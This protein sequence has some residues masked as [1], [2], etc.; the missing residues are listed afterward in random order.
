MNN[1][2]PKFRRPDILQ[3]L[4]HREYLRTPDLFPKGSDGFVVED[5][6]LVIRR[7]GSTIFQLDEIGKFMLCEFKILPATLGKAQWRTFIL[8][9]K[10]LRKS[11][12]SK[13]RYAGYYLIQTSDPDW[14]NDNCK[15]LIN[16]KPYSRTDFNDFFL[17]KLTIEGLFEGIKFS[18]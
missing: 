3:I 13:Q 16:H 8:I 1:G 9:D 6:D 10:L 2:N 15:F 18:I 4:P 7:F 14:L 5:L 12:P 17:G 11:D